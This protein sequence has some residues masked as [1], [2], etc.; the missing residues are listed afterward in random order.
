MRFSYILSGFLAALAIASP[1]AR[2]EEV[3]VTE[4][5]TR[6]TY[7]D[8]AEFTAAN[9]V[10]PGLQNGQYYWFTLEWPLGAPVGDGDKE[11][12]TELQQLQQKLGFEHIGVVVG[13]VTE[14]TT[15]KGKNQKTKRDFNAVLYHMTKKNVN[16]G[17]VELKTANW[18]A[19][20]RKNLKGG[21]VTSSKKVDAAKKVAKNWAV[22]KA[23]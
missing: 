11:S 23:L 17:D 8:T 4:L 13:K 7:Q 19:D 21:Q 10:H 2:P 3:D 15:G 20:P 22:I 16:P 12:Q 14:T 9:S 6:E 18:K 1:I 5:V